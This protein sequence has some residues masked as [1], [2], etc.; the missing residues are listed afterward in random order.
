MPHKMKSQKRGEK[1]KPQPRNQDGGFLYN[2][3]SFFTDIINKVG[4]PGA[5]LIAIYAYVW[6][7]GS[8]EIH[9]R[10]IEKYI[11]FEWKGNYWNIVLTI[12]VII[13]IFLSNH[14]YC[15]KQ[16]TLKDN[17]IKRLVKERNKLQ[18]KLTEKKLHHGDTQ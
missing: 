4:W 7:F 9:H 15:K 5:C 13:L 16:L 2:V 1:Y 17:E 11:L 3:G 8:K 18:E 6:K 10:I 14:I 12:A